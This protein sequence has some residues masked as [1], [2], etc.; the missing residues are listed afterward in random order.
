MQ[1]YSKCTVC[2]ED[3]TESEIEISALVENETH[4]VCDKCLN[5]KGTKILEIITKASS[6]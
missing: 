5:E 4:P 2:Y 1:V 6:K 3:L